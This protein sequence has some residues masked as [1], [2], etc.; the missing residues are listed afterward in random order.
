[1][2]RKIIA[3]LVPRLAALLM[4]VLHATLRVR[5]LHPERMESMNRQGRPY[6]LAFWHCYI[7][8]MVF[9]RHRKPISVMISRNKDGEYIATTMERFGV[10][11]TRGSSSRGGAAALQ[12]LIDLA[13]AGENIAITPDGPRGPARVAQVGVV[14]GASRAGTPIIPVAVISERKKQLSSWDRFEIPKPFSRA[15][16]VYG[17]PIEVPPGIEGD[18]LESWR[19]KIERAMNELSDDAERNFDALWRSA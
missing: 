14:I 15:M 18:D 1:V 8:L 13:A 11:S 6:M 9:S 7:L 16:Y 2:K 10:K 17:E 5:H 12:E 4:R 19:A 3:F